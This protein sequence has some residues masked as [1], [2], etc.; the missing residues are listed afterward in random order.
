MYHASFAPSIL[1]LSPMFAPVA[2]QSTAHLLSMDKLEVW[3]ILKECKKL[4]P[5]RFPPFF[6]FFLLLFSHGCDSHQTLL[7]TKELRESRWVGMS[8][9]IQSPSLAPI[10]FCSLSSTDLCRWASSLWNSSA[11]HRMALSIYSLLCIFYSLPC[12][13]N[14]PF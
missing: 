4:D 3:C 14:R 8:S 9:F 12:T 7:L 2:L 5:Q 10:L 1:P 11:L 6:F 13:Q